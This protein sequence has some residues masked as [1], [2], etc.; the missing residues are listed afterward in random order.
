MYKSVREHHDY[1]LRL[2]GRFKRS[3]LVRSRVPRDSAEHCVWREGMRSLLYARNEY[4][5]F[6][7]F[8]FRQTF[9]IVESFCYL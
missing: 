6:F 9:S 8:F 7:F 1:V 3:E 4:F 2:S 5:F